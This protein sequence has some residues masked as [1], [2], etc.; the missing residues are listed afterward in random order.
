MHQAVIQ[1]EVRYVKYFVDRHVT[2]YLPEYDIEK[3]TQIFKYKTIWDGELNSQI[4]NQGDTIYIPELDSRAV[5]TKRIIDIVDNVVTYE[6]N[7]LVEIVENDETKASLEY[8][9]K[10]LD[11]HKESQ[12]IALERVIEMENRGEI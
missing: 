6:T 11:F 9:E 12:R 8:A 2:V 10:L 4:L 7:Y 1:G 5:I 3:K